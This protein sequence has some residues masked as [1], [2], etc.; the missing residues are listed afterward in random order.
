MP[1]HIEVFN[2][3]N[4]DE[5]D[6]FN[7]LYQFKAFQSLWLDSHLQKNKFCTFTFSSLHQTTAAQDGQK[8]RKLRS[9]IFLYKRSEQS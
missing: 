9:Q 1:E 5:L 8:S 6:F 3:G 2:K 7:L 4:F